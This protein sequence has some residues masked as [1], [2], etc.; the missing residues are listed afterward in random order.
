MIIHPGLVEVLVEV[1]LFF[2]SFKRLVLVLSNTMRLNEAFHEKKK[3]TK[4]R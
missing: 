2:L 1:V 3:L 4:T